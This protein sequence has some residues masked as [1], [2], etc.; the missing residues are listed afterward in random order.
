MVLGDQMMLLECGEC[1]F[2]TPH[3]FLLIPYAGTRCW[4]DLAEDI[5]PFVALETVDKDDSL[6]TYIDMN[7]QRD[8]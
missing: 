4:N 6:E 8:C 2:S 1:N 5:G 7:M 3:S